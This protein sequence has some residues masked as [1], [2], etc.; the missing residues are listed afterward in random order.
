MTKR[1]QVIIVGGGFGGLFAAQ[2]LKRANVDITLIDRRNFHLPAKFLEEAQLVRYIQQIKSCGHDI[3][4]RFGRS[5]QL[6]S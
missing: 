2:N 3:R 1:P 4:P 5:G 6:P